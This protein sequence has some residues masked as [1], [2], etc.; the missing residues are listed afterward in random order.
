MLP[1]IHLISFHFQMFQSFFNNVKLIL[2]DEMHV[3]KGVFGTHTACVFRRLSRVCANYLVPT[4]DRME[5]GGG[6]SNESRGRWIGCSATA[7]NGLN[8]FRNLT[9]VEGVLVSEGGAP[10]SQVSPIMTLTLL[11]TPHWIVSCWTEI[12][13]NLDSTHEWG[14]QQHPSTSLFAIHHCFPQGGNGAQPT[15]TPS[16]APARGEG[17]GCSRR[18]PG[19]RGYHVRGP[20]CP[21]L[22]QVT[23]SV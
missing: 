7:T 22:L 4:D 19:S 14:Y 17:P 20:L 2:I 6:S 5:G 16:P 10:V 13:V 1:E 23:G 18:S 3:Y 11:S 15:S 12:D 21:C 9:G 8:L